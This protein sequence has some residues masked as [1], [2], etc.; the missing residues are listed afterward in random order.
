MTMRGPYFDPGRLRHEMVLEE[1]VRVADALGGQTEDW[2]AVAALW[3]HLEPAANVVSRADAEEAE[4]SHRVVLRFDTR[5][6]RG[7]RLR[8]GGRIFDIRAVRDLDETGRYLLCL[9]REETS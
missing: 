2:Q 7:R 4:I 9:T 5:V 1:P 6:W 8:S 3:G